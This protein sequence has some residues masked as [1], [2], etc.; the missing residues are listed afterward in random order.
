MKIAFAMI[1]C[2]RRDGTARAILEVAERLAL[3]HE[4]TLFAR[5]VEDADPAHLRVVRV[6]APAK[7]G[8]LRFGVYHYLMDRMINPREFDIIHSAGNNTKH[9]NV[10]TIQNIQPAKAKI[11]RELGGGRKVS[12]ARRVSHSLYLAVTTH[13]EK[14]MYPHGRGRDKKLFLPVSSGVKKNLLDHYDIGSSPVV[15]IPNAADTNKYK[16][17][18]GA[19]RKEWRHANGLEEDDIIVAFAGG[20][21][22]RKGLRFAIEGIAGVKEPQLKLFVA[23]TDP[24]LALY[25]RLAIDLGCADRVIFGEFRKDINLVL[26]ASDIFLFPSWYEAFSLATLEAAACGLPIIATRINGTEDFIQPSVN[27]EFIEHDGEQICAILK[28]LIRC[29]ETI[30]EMGNNARR[31]VEQN[32]TWE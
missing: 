19:V 26:G 27:G 23:G 12:P 29:K 11:M 20:E 3:E 10:I 31:I 24:E 9:A 32:Y 18:Q 2:N 30:R 6:P 14:R 1:D 22:R 25:E 21:W 17:L 15:N 28:Q 5:E 7:P 16:P 8:A 13:A 4:V